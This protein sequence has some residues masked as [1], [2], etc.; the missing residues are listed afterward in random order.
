MTDGFIELD[1]HRLDV[2]EHLRDL[3]AFKTLHGR[4]QRGL[5]NAGFQ[6]NCGAFVD[7]SANPSAPTIA[8]WWLPHSRSIWMR[9][10]VSN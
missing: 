8:A 10:F 5:A 1:E 6:K 3:A 4:L 9:G 7:A 2:H